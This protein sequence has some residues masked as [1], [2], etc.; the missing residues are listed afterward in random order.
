[1]NLSPYEYARI[2]KRAQDLEA[3]LLDF[4][5]CALRDIISGDWKIDGANDPD[6]HIYWVFKN[7]YCQRGELADLM[8][9]YFQGG[10]AHD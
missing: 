8:T 3:T 10:P 5:E 7:T 6:P 4:T 9:E 1:M 2:C